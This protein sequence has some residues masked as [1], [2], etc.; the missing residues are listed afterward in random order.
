[1]DK[2]DIQSEFDVQTL[3]DNFYKQ[4]LA[5]P[6]IGFIFIDV[7]SIEWEKHMPIMYSFWNTM[8]LGTAS[9]SGNPMEKHIALNSK[10]P[11]TKNHFDRWLVL[12]E[13]TVN[14]NFKGE[15]ANEAIAR[16]KNIAALM[17]HHIS[18]KRSDKL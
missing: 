9:Y 15:K 1:M 3:V 17:Q 4:V 2:H 8:L 16:A 12:W 18:K 13:K 10:V 6:T 11:L 5:D 14:E 7:A